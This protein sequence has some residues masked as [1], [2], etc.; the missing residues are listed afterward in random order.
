MFKPEDT[1]QYTAHVMKDVFTHRRHQRY[2]LHEYKSGGGGAPHGRRQVLLPVCYR[3][4]VMNRDG[5][6]GDSPVRAISVGT[7]A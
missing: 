7:S 2:R 3:S 4:K 5:S 6:K 1:H